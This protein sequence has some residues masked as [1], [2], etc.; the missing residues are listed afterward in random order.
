MGESGAGKTTLLNVLAQRVGGVGVVT[1]ERFFSGQ[2]LPI[3]FQ[4][5]TGYCQQLDAH[6]PE[7]TVREALLFSANLHQPQ[8]VPLAEK[9]AYIDKCLQMCG[10]EEYADTIVG[11]LGV[12][13]RKRTTIAVELAAKPK[14]L[15]F[16]DELT[17][18]LDSQSA[19]A[20]VHVLREL[21]DRGQAILCT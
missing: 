6:L 18:G 1:G 3:D 8:S 20:I 10:L 19:W 12:E 9:E 5:Q 14:L 21:T 17:S 11:S 2:P 4:A 15:L 16:L 7:A 13:C